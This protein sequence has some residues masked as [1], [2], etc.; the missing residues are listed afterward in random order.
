MNMAGA[1][2]E[3]VSRFEARQIMK[4]TLRRMQEEGDL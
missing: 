1:Q 2:L 3:G 4:D